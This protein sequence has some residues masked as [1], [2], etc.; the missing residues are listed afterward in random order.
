MGEFGLRLKGLGFKDGWPLRG[1][2]GSPPRKTGLKLPPLGHAII[3][4]YVNP[5]PDEIWERT[6]LEQT[7]GLEFCGGQT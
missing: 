6:E 1:E 4:C 2:S 3:S 7:R 5:N